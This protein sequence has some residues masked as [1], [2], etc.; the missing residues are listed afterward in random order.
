MRL[1]CEAELDDGVRGGLRLLQVDVQAG[2][3]AL[4]APG[5]LPH[6]A[7]LS[8]ASRGD[9]EDVRALA[10]ELDEVRHLALPVPE[11]VAG[12]PLADF[13]LEAAAGANANA[14]ANVFV[15]IGHVGNARGGTARSSRRAIKIVGVRASTAA[16][17]ARPT[18]PLPLPRAA[19]GPRRAGVGSPSQGAPRP[20]QGAPRPA[21]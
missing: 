13:P 3:L 20:A 8:N 17:G 21:Q 10:Q 11:P 19:V 4:D 18:P 2:E 5:H 15:A 9:Q 1:G 12:H 14:N 16:G 7:R 6:E